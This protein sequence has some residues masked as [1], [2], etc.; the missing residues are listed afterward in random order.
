MKTGSIYIIKNKVNDKVYIGQTTLSVRERFNSHMKPSTHKRRSSYKIY[1]AMSK[2][3][4]DKFY[5]EVLEENV[6]IDKLDDL[7][8]KY[9]EEYDSYRNGYNSTKGGDGRIINKIEDEEKVVELIKSGVK[10][11]EVAEMFDVHEYTIRRLLDKLNIKIGAYGKITK[12]VLE[13]CDSKGMTN[14]EIAEMYNVHNHTVTRARTKYGM[15][16]NN[17]PV[18][19][20]DEFDYEKFKLDFQDK[21]SKKYMMEKYTLSS[22][23]YYRLVDKLGL[24]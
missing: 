7:E 3:G 16:K 18:K 1:N 11:E 24:K 14:K 15:R 22:T 13:E 5:Y 9:I 23:S 19:C 17:K 8:I 6:E 21:Q 12:E 4:S 10:L 20:R 2:Y